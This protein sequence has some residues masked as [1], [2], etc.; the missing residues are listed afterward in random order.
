MKITELT[1]AP[2]LTKITL[3][4]E[5]LV[6]KYGDTIE[7][8]VWDRQP[9]EKYVALAQGGGDA[10]AVMAVAKEL[11]LDED[12][13]PVM[14]GDQVLPADVAMRALTKVIETLGK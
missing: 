3:D 6:T 2:Q 12:G 5:V 13:K 10:A 14:T 1:A 4:D 8:F 11:I 9:M 7:F